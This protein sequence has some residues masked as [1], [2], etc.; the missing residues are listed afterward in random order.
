MTVSDLS[1]R[2]ALGIDIG[3]TNTK[4]GL[5]NHR[6][7][8]LGKGRIKTDYDDIDDFINTLYKEI[9]PILEQHDAKSQ[10]EGIG[11]GAPNGNYYKGTIE[12]APN[13]KWKGIVP[14]AEKITAKFGV[15]CKVTNDA[16]AAAYGEMM[17]GAA[18]GMKDFIMITLGTGVGSGVIANGQLVYGH[19]GF[20]GEL[21][22][23]IV[24]PG[25][26]KHW[27]TGS[28]GSLEAYASATGIAITAKKM[29]AEF[30]ESMLN[31]Y[32]EEQINAKTVHECALEGDPT[33]VEVFRYTG[34]KLGEA[35]ANFVMFSS[36]EAILLFGG[37][38][39]AGDFI[40]K[41]TRLHM[42]RNLLPIFRGK[43]KLVFSELDEADAAILGA[44][45][46]VWEK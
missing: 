16:N 5:V 29:R 30:P 44:S 13:L 4:F 45:S 6:G 32:P 24:K 7:E 37:V 21:G 46:L 38:I 10:L 11:I 20:A 27:S 26:R 8:I 42:E 39:K 41:P 35:L 1:S 25:G 31:N 23:T 40:L 33:A 28:E 19:D 2:M 14:L 15:P 18:R 34:Q 36:P 22:H 12:N 17:F 3:G 9:E 43:V